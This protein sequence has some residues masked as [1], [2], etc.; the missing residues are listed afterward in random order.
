MQER[1]SFMQRW[2]QFRPSK[3]ALFWSCV[4]SVVATI[5]VGLS[6]GGWVTGGTARE[7]TSD[8]GDQ[9]RQELAAS[10]CVERFATGPDARAQLVSLK[11]MASSYRQRDFV[12]KGGWAT[13]PGMTS[14]ERQAAS[15]CAE[16]LVKLDLPP[17]E[18]ASEISDDAAVAQ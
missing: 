1:Q 6:V 13:M 9:A 15:L 12:A 10:V 11:E 18:E 8:A 17:T 7:M 3:T 16:Q 2:D 4:G 14:A 5:V